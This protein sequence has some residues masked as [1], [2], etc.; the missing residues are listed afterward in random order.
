MKKGMTN[1]MKKN[2]FSFAWVFL[3]N[4][5]IA[6]DTSIV[7]KINN[8]QFLFMSTVAPKVIFDKVFGIDQMLIAGIQYVSWTWLNCLKKV[9]SHGV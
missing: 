1:E 7:N 2:H 8:V 6:A 9:G 5:I 3:K 4:K